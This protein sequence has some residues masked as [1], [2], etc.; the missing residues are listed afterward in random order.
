M[1]KSEEWAK[2]YS[3]AVEFQA[4][5]LAG[6]QRAQEELGKLLIKESPVRTLLMWLNLYEGDKFA[7]FEQLVKECEPKHG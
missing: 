7:R 4:A 6:F 1:R 3:P 2:E 5:Y